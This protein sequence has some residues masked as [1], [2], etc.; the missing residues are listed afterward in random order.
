MSCPVKGV[1]HGTSRSVLQDKLADLTQRNSFALVADLF[2]EDLF[3]GADELNRLS[4]GGT[5]LLGRSTVKN[6]ALSLYDN[7][8]R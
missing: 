6:L 8:D 1:A 7:F 3:E 5:S 4:L 2:G